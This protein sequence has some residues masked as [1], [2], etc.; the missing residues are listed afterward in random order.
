MVTLSVTRSRVSDVLTGTAR[1]LEAEGWDPL[2]QRIV[3]TID[4]AAGYTPGSGSRD[5]E[6]TTLDAYETLADHLGV[7]SVG[8]WEQDP[9]RT[10]LQ[11][12]AALHGAAAKAVTW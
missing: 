1:L 10:Q 7:P 6:Q 8:D 12:V 5:G 3:P 4:R 11:V 9:G 2:R